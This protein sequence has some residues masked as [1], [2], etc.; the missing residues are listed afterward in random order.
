[1]PEQYSD[2]PNIVIP[3]TFLFCMLAFVFAALIAFVVTPIVKVLAVK[4]KAIDIPNDTRRIHTKPIPRLGGLAI[5]FAFIIGVLIFSE[6]TKEIFGII[7]GTFFIVLLGIIDDIKSLKPIVKLVGQIIIAFIPI[8]FDIVI[9]GANFFGT[10]IE[11]G[12]FSIPLTILWIVSLTNA[13]NLIDGLDGLACGVATISSITILIF[14]ITNSDFSIIILLA[15]LTGA[16]LGFLPY[17]S[18]PAH[19]FMGDTGALFLGYVL[20]LISIMGFFKLNAVVSFFTP[21]LIFAL[22]L[23]DTLSAVIRRF[24]NKQSPF[25]ADKN[26][27]HHKLLYIGFS[28]KKS[29]YILYSF[30]AL[31]GISG[32]LFNQARY[33]S[34]I[35]IIIIVFLIYYLN[36][37]SLNKDKNDQKNNK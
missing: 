30:S 36:L 12:V 8:C 18:N 31:F 11:F 21:F 9:K 37:Y 7:L 13:L 22:P 15:I 4:I 25:T 3:E 20:S 10:Y 27:L 24:K 14:A 29:V 33:I 32:L 19:I 23:F 2:S 26:H 17:N 16:C 5:F 1:M 28:Q 6:L 34:A 35:L